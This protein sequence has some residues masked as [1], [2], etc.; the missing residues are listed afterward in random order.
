[1]IRPSDW[2]ASQ[3]DELER[4]K[5]PLGFNVTRLIAARRNSLRHST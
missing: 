3:L 5:I 1:M 2:Q 4:R